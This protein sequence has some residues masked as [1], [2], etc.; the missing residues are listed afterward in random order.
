MRAA[1]PLKSTGDLSIPSLLSLTISLIIVVNGIGYAATGRQSMLQMNSPEHAQREL[2]PAI[3][4]NSALQDPTLPSARELAS[5]SLYCAFYILAWL[6]FRFGQPE[7]LL[8][9]HII[10]PWATELDLCSHQQGPTLDRDSTCSYCWD[11]M[12][13]DD[14]VLKHSVC[15]HSWHTGC[16]KTWADSRDAGFAM[17]PICG[18][19]LTTAGELVEP[20]GQR[21]HGWRPATMEL[22]MQRLSFLCLLLAIFIMAMPLLEPVF[23]N[24]EDFVRTHEALYYHSAVW[25]LTSGQVQSHW[26]VVKW[27]GKKKRIWKNAVW[28]VLSHLMA[29][30]LRPMIA[31][32]QS[33][34][35]SKPSP[36]WLPVL[37]GVITS[38]VLLVFN[39]EALVWNNERGALIMLH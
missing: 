7:Y 38:Y 32:D 19:S 28:I 37:T 35:I 14:Q 33:G 34:D 3:T 29:L 2:Q 24:R 13:A 15:R 1:K 17:C 4:F 6:C 11:I 31:Q 22:I 10:K 36:H 39:T 26:V 30:G 5:T 27:M 18:C 9:S 16:L 20:N 12:N 23:H 25:L 8:M 21:G